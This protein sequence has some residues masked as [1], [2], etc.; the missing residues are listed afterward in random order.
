MSFRHP[1]QNSVI[2]FDTRVGERYAI[3]DTVELASPALILEMLFVIPV[4]EASERR[5]HELVILHAYWP[6]YWSDYAGKRGR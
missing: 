5:N 2:L 3:S 6:S 1:A 4:T